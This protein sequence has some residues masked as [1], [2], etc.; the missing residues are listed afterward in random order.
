VLGVGA[1]VA[2]VIVFYGLLWRPLASGSA[3][4]RD[5]VERKSRLLVDLERVAALAPAASGAVPAQGASQSLL[6]LVDNTS[7]QHGLAGKLTRTR[8]DGPDGINVTVQDASFDAL[9][10]WIVALRASYG[11]DVESASI[12]GSRTPGL[13][14]GQLL[15]RRN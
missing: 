4:L 9:L 13:V 8:Q 2:A 3:E 6:V 5:S 11:V 15:L 10:G 1:I 7:K 14:S 12:N